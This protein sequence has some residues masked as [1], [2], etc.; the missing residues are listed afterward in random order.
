VARAMSLRQRARYIPDMSRAMS[1]NDYTKRSH[2]ARAARQRQLARVRER[3]WRCGGVAPSVCD[4]RETW[5]RASPARANAGHARRSS[6]RNFSAKR[7]SAERA[8][9][10]RAGVD[11]TFA[12]VRERCAR[13]RALAASD[14]WHEHAVAHGARV[15]K[16]HIRA[17]TTSNETIGA[18]PMRAPRAR[19]REIA[20]HARA[21]PQN[22]ARSVSCA[23]NEKSVA[24]IFSAAAAR[25]VTL[26]AAGCLS[27][28]SLLT[29]LHQSCRRRERFVH[30]CTCGGREHLL[31]SEHSTPSCAV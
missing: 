21:A 1:G 11:E 26:A 2:P 24:R 8:A 10:P 23:T 16:L 5:A 3:R 19:A 29:V 15:G 20:I 4:W 22:G 12:S 13:V 9:Y 17:S 30:A 7:T 14:R 18:V 28:L 31:C 27:N 25:E 6:T